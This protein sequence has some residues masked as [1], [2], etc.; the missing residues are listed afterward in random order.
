M[1]RVT[2]EKNQPMPTTVDEWLA[3]LSKCKN[4]SKALAQCG[5]IILDRWRQRSYLDELMKTVLAGAPPPR[6]LDPG[7]LHKLSVPTYSRLLY[8]CSAKGQSTGELLPQQ[9]TLYVFDTAL[10]FAR[11]FWQESASPVRIPWPHAER[12]IKNTSPLLDIVSFT[13]REGVCQIAARAPLSAQ[14]G[15]RGAGLGW[16]CGGG[17]RSRWTITRRRTRFRG[18]SAAATPSTSCCSTSS[19]AAAPT[20]FPARRLRPK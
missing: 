17:D 5:G 4:F 11:T 8:S 2:E 15:M 9:G 10:C 12:V 7:L 19:P 1:S 13:V 16:G 18:W 6:A 20:R 3:E 14:R